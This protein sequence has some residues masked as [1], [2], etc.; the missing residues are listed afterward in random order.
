MCH[1]CGE[2]L[3]LSWDAY[4][5]DIIVSLTLGEVEAIA[6][7]IKNLLNPALCYIHHIVDTE[8]ERRELGPYRKK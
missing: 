2:S 4:S 6:E 7:Q 3:L 1:E 8:Y 5:K